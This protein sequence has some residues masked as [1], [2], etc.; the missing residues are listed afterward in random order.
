MKSSTKF[1][2]AAIGACAACCAV[3]AM[4]ALLA[5]AGLAAVG[6]AAL[7]WGAGIAAA[8]AIPAAV[9]T[10][11]ARR[12]RAADPGAP[13]LA[14]C[15][16]SAS[17][18]TGPAEEETPIAC[19]LDGSAFAERTAAI[20]DLAGRSLRQVSRKPLSIALTYAPEALDAVRDL[21]RQE[22]ACCAF[23]TY[24]VRAEPQG[25]VLTIAA[26]PAAAEAADEIFAHLAP[27]AAWA[28]EKETV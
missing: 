11:R 14:G 18:A 22:Q 3:G 23:M 2:G 4:P 20:R 26:P 21:V 28:A 7:W 10:L 19:T 8:L 25:V 5:G 15:G 17:C 9:V 6:G 27:D 24:E 1:A 12:R 16:C 13:A